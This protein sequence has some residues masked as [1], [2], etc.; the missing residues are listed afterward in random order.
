[1]SVTRCTRSRKWKLFTPLTRI[2]QS[3]PCSGCLSMMAG[4][5]PRLMRRCSFPRLDR[6][7]FYAR[8]QVPCREPVRDYQFN[9][10]AYLPLVAPV[11]PL[12]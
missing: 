9:L 2:Q 8:P 12:K 10:S 11:P 5:V 1:M 4:K 7:L 6:T 3:G